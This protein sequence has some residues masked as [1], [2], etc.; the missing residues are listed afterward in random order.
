[1]NEESTEKKRAPRPYED[2]PKL[3][4]SPKGEHV[5]ARSIVQGAVARA[6]G[7]ARPRRILVRARLWQ[8]PR[9]G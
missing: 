1:M 6:R 2:A 4:E 7:G 8:S 9:A 3:P 5:D